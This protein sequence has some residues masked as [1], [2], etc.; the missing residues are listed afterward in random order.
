VVWD[1]VLPPGADGVTMPALDDDLGTLL[2]GAEG[3]TQTDIY[4]RHLDSSD[5]TDFAALQAGGLHVEETV[6][7]ST[8]VPR[9]VNG[10]VRTAY[11]LGL[12]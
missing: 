6:D 10:S 3:I 5:L 8:I 7:E 11:T 9:P 4:L 2:S 12:R 1:A